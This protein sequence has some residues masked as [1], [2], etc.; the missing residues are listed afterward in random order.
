[1]WTEKFGSSGDSRARFVE[2]Q[3]DKMYRYL[4]RADMLSPVMCRKGDG[5]RVVIDLALQ[6][7]QCDAEVW[8]VGFTSLCA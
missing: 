8:T 4:C 2:R 7:L 5:I 6:T 1:M 3:N